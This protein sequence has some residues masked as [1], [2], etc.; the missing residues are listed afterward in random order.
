MSR[1]RA[2]PPAPHVIVTGSS[3]AIGGAL[4]RRIVDAVERGH[5]RVIDPAVY[6]LG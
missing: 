2:L 6:G 5:A 1:T 3:G 4:A